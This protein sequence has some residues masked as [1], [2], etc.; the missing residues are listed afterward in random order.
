MV[1]SLNILENSDI[2]IQE[3]VM[4]IDSFTWFGVIFVIF[5]V[6]YAMCFL[7]ITFYPESI[8]AISG[9]MT[10]VAWGTGIFFILFIVM[11]VL[12]R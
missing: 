11:Y 10:I 8:L 7:S 3:S 12:K 6:I 4:I 2:V 5:A 1:F 9:P